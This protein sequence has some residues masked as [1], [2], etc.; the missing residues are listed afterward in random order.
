[1]IYLHTSGI[2]ELPRATISLSIRFDKLPGLLDIVG[3]E[4]GRELGP[5]WKIAA[6]INSVEETTKGAL[7]IHASFPRRHGRMAHIW[8]SEP[9]ARKDGGREVR[10][11]CPC[12][13]D[14]SSTRFTYAEPKT[15]EVI[16]R[17]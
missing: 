6:A 10:L 11:A 9:D 7:R 13:D 8:L 4:Y 2:E 3:T 12:D 16:F 5:L 1:M 17:R 14:G 15:F